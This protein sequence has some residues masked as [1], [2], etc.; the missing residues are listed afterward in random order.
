MRYIFYTVLA[1]CLPF[2][3]MAQ[4]PA[5][6]PT[7]LQFNSVKQ[8]TAVLAFTAS[9]ADGFLVLKAN[10]PVSGVPQDGVTYQKGQSLGNAKVAYNGS[11]T[12][13]SLREMLE[14]T[15]YHFAIYAYNGSGAGINYRQTGPLTGSLTTPAASPGSY[16]SG[17]DSSSG[18]LLADLKVLIFPHTL[19]AY[20]A[21]KN[22]IVPALYER[23]TIGNG[24]VVNC[25]YSNETTVYIPPFDFVGINYSREH[26]LP[27]SWMLTGGN[28]NNADGA[29]YHN[30][31][32]TRLNDVNTVRSNNPL[33]IVLNT[34]SS[35]IECKYGTDNS[36]NNVFEPRDDRK[37]DAARAMFYQMVC[38]NG[39]SGNWG[40]DFL[41]SQAT[42]Q[43]QNILKLW[44]QQDPPDA[45][46]RTKNEYIYS[47]QNNRNPFIDNP[48][49]VECINFDS[50]VKTALCGFISGVEEN[51]LSQLVSVFPN[52]A[53]QVLHIHSSL[54]FDVLEIELADIA[55]RTL[56]KS[57][58]HSNTTQVDVSAVES[59]LYLLKLEANGQTAFKPCIIRHE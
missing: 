51:K 26:A 38:Y 44:H 45:F 54:P 21:Y 56:W 15:T 30:L 31:L 58:M 47:L 34:T 46:E 48:G 33:G 52:P 43:D 22:N 17:I 53:H 49:W 23:D 12:F 20:T 39:Q 25:E 16:Y 13:V 28:T 27:R 2:M 1:F 18:T 32:L 3:A 57:H 14:N 41:L 11:G 10:A 42:E 29:D 6:N 8:W 7:N 19:V 5:A 37:G 40:L 4:E 9:Q 24:A 36:G 55:G 35:Y 59:G 50:L